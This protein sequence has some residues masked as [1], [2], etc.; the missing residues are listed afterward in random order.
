V[1]KKESQRER[2]TCCIKAHTHTHVYIERDLERQLSYV[3]GFVH[4]YKP[5][6]G[7]LFYLALTPCSGVPLEKPVVIQLVKNLP[8]FNIT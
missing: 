6:K 5:K 4:Q 7:L 8:T 2:H 1:G 3:L